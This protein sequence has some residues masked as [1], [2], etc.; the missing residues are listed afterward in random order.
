MHDVTRLIYIRIY[1]LSI[2]IVDIAYCYKYDYD[3]VDMSRDDNSVIPLHKFTSYIHAIM[4][5][6]APICL[7]KY[8]PFLCTLK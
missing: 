1:E 8:N 7:Q 4:F 3:I 5:P 2:V 6:V